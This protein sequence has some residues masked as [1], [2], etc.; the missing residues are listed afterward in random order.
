M[1]CTKSKP[2][3]AQVNM[4]TTFL[5]DLPLGHRAAALR[6]NA[7]F[8]GCLQH[9]SFSF[10]ACFRDCI[11]FFLPSYA[12]LYTSTLFLK[13][14]HISP[15]GDSLGRCRGFALVR[16]RKGPYEGLSGRQSGITF[17]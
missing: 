2:K 9:F 4:H 16:H 5:Q 7:F 13:L 11:F 17:N 3:Q 1:F 14:Q 10:A 15:Y 12:S 6:L 8:F